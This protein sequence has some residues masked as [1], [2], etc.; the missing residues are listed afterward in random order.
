M[1]TVFIEETD[2]TNNWIAQNEKNLTAP[3][4]VRC[5]TQRAGRGQRGNSW[6]SEPGKNFTGSVLLKPESFPASRQFLLSEAV[7][8]AVKDT[9]EEYGIKAKVKWPNDIYVG[10]KKICGILVE[11]VVTGC[12]IT[13]TI[14][15]IGV[16]VNQECFYS[17]APN[18]TSMVIETGR[19]YNLEEV[20]EKLGENIGRRVGIPDTLADGISVNPESLHSEFTAS[21]WRNDGQFHP[22]IDKKRGE[23][24]LARIE[25]VGFDGMLTVTTDS[26]E[27]REFAFK[28]IEF[29]I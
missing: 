11:H 26:G 3:V 14:A 9:L 23:T 27:K 29:V 16:N 19:I 2:S 1:E 13:R 7:A 6:E 25:N 21:L 8:L 20:S 18:P 17:D 12:N 5:H 24:I 15:G 28:E 10:N 22:F 4:V